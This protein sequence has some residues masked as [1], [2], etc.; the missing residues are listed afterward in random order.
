MVSAVSGRSEPCNLGTTQS[1]A[2]RAKS[3]QE[4]MGVLSSFSKRCFD[5]SVAVLLILLLGGPMAVIAVAI[6]LSSPGPPLFRQKRIGQWG[7]PFWIYKFRTMRVAT[8]GAL[9]T[10]ANDSR[11]TRVGRWLRRWKLDELPQLYNV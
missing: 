7:Y 2:G 9:I 4:G 3:K 11:I 10:S 5:L 1:G 8:G 6:K